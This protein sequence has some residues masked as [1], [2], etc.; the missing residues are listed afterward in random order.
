M[1]LRRIKTLAAQIAF[2]R[3]FCVTCNVTHN[4]VKTRVTESE[5]LIRVNGAT[6]SSMEGN[7][8][9]ESV[10]RH[11]NKFSAG[12]VGRGVCTGQMMDLHFSCLCIGNPHLHCTQLM[13]PTLIPQQPMHTGQWCLDTHLLWSLPNNNAYI[14]SYRSDLRNKCDLPAVW[15]KP[16]TF[17]SARSK[18]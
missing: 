18:H 13:T 9:S 3:V 2:Q 12:T 17:L 1:C 7:T 5:Q 15:S 16:K 14:K 8:E 6:E 11:W 4:N 10:D